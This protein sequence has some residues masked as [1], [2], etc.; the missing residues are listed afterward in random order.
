MT[1]APLL[2]SCMRI[3]LVSLVLACDSAPEPACK[4]NATTCVCHG[5]DSGPPVCPSAAVARGECSASDPA[6]MGCDDRVGNFTC[7]CKTDD[8]GLHWF[9]IGTERS[10]VNE[11]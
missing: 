6:C 3:F 7:T 8:S 10:C 4:C 9:C 2:R 11:P 1:S 5:A